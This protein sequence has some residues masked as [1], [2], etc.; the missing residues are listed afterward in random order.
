MIEA[1]AGARWPA[2]GRRPRRGC[3]GTSAAA[4]G[5]PPLAPAAGRPPG[6]RELLRRPAAGPT[7][8]STARGIDGFY[9][10]PLDLELRAPGVDQLVLAGF[11]AEAAVDSTLRAPTTGATSASR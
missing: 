11:G 10:S 7:S 5:R 9:A 8:S 6:Q 4:A 1:V 2:T 3:G